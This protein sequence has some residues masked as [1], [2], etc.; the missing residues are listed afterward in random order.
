MQKLKILNTRE[1]KSIK[2]KLKEQ[3]GISELGDYVFLLN[4]KGKLFFINKD[5]SRIEVDKLKVD[6]YG[7]YF[8]E[9]RNE[10]LRLSMQGAGLIGKKAKKNVVEISKEEIQDYFIGLDLDKDFGEGKKFVLLKYG[11]DIV[12]CAKYKEG[13]VLNFLPKI[14]RTKDLIV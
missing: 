7:L 6:K 11:D 5:L 8:G 12:G 3:F 10:E 13:K 2:E 1:V 4:N 14:N 9:L